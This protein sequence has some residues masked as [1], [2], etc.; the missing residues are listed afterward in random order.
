VRTSTNPKRLLWGAI[1][2]AAFL[3]GAEMCATMS[4]T[5]ADFS[6]WAM[7]A[8]VTIAGATGTG[9]LAGTPAGEAAS[10][11]P[12]RATRPPGIGEL[13]DDWSRFEDGWVEA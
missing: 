3:V 10:H 12:T 13:V 2:F 7:V 9:W 6:V 1:F 4:R 11:Q 8:V 5:G